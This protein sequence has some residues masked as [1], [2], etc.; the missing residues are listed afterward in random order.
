VRRFLLSLAVLG[1]TDR[2]KVFMFTHDGLTRACRLAAR[3]GRLTRV[4][5]EYRIAQMV[6]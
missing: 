5:Y 2:H 4:I 1:F 3:A 6:G